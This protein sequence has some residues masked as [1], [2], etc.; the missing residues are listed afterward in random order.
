MIDDGENR[1]SSHKKVLHRTAA[2]CSMWVQKTELQ[3]KVVYE[4]LIVGVS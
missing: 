4:G 2:S 1:L 3:S